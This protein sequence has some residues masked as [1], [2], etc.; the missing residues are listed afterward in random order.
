MENLDDAELLQVKNQEEERKKISNGNLQELTSQLVEILE[1][2]T[3]W[4]LLGYAQDK[5][6]KSYKNAQ[7]RLLESSS[8]IRSSHTLQSNVKELMLSSHTLQSNVKELRKKLMYNLDDAEDVNKSHPNLQRFAFYQAGKAVLHTELPLH[9][10]VSFLPL[11]PQIFHR[12]ASDLSNLISPQ[13]TSEPQRRVM[14]ETRLI[15]V[16]AGKAGELLGLSQCHNVPREDKPDR[17]LKTEWTQEGS[18]F[19]RPL[20]TRGYTFVKKGIEKSDQG[21]FPISPGSKPLSNEES[22]LGNRDLA[23]SLARKGLS[24]QSDLGVEELSFAG[25]LANHMITT[26]YLYSKKISLQKVTLA[27]I[28]QEKS[29]IEIDDPVLLDLFRHLE[30]TIEDEVRLAGR[31]SF[32]YQQRFA[33]SWWQTHTMGEESLVEPKESNWYRLYIPDPEETERNIDWV[34]PDDHYHSVAANLLRNTSQNIVSRSIKQKRTF[35]NRMGKGY[36]TGLSV[37]WND[38]YLINRDYIYQGLVSSC[39]HKAINLLDKKRELL[40]LFADQLIRYNLLRQHEIGIIW[41]QFHTVAVSTTKSNQI[42]PNMTLSPSSEKRVAKEDVQSV[43]PESFKH[44][45]SPNDPEKIQ[46]VSKV[47]QQWGSYSRREK[48]KFI[49]FDFVKPCFLTKRDV[50]NKEEKEEKN[51]KSIKEGSVDPSQRDED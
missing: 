12:S 25:L 49:D 30:R 36:P 42:S 40:D 26:W 6:E 1:D 22:E 31:A 29:E 20:V 8:D 7:N 2:K 51:V 9:P 41:Q 47:K 21:Q 27:H 18:V 32:R 35:A 45:T 14:L 23:G 33:P 3:V 24:L 43:T 15:G 46:G 10:S 48:A 19:A 44:L 28:S 34:A 37:T 38:L 11:E 50:A 39:F 4:R 17:D 13:G 16:Y 5:K